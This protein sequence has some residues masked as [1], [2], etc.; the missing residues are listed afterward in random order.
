MVKPLREDHAGPKIATVVQK[1]RPSLATITI[2]AI[3]E[4]QSSAAIRKTL[5]VRSFKVADCLASGH[6]KERA[7][8]FEF[9]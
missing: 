1:Y 3:R 5:R 6:Q 2:L 4:Q 9:G 8:L 7:R